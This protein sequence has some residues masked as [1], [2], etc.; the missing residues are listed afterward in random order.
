MSLKNVLICSCVFSLAIV[1][2]SY[3]I[4]KTTLKSKNQDFRISHKT[5]IGYIGW[6]FKGSWASNLSVLVILSTLLGAN[7]IFIETEEGV[8]FIAKNDYISFN[9]LLVLLLALSPLLYNAWRSPVKSKD[10]KGNTV[11]QDQGY[12]GAFLIASFV[13][14]F[15]VSSNIGAMW[16]LSKSENINL[17][18]SPLFRIVLGVAGLSLVLYVYTSFYSLILK[19]VDVEKPAQREKDLQPPE[20]TYQESLPPI[21]PSSSI[22]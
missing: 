7:S 17:T 8:G 10:S 1:L 4:I 14:L 11:Y 13:T 16:I 22:L 5:R 2:V 15:A 19:M 3:L 9:I 20:G 6:D 21:L 18:F 12:L